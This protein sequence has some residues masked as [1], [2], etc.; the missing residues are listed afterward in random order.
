MFSFV[1]FPFH[2]TMNEKAEVNFY[3]CYAIHFLKYESGI[4]SETREH[5]TFGVAAKIDKYVTSRPTFRIFRTRYYSTNKH[6]SVAEFGII[7]IHT[8]TA[9]RYK[10]AFIAGTKGD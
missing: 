3:A 7:L 9:L 1:F 4:L 5:L 8:C 6:I 10:P 2:W